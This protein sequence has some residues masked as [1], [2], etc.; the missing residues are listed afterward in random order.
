M[1]LMSWVKYLVNKTIN[2]KVNAL[3]DK[4]TIYFFIVNQCIIFLTNL[5]QKKRAEYFAKINAGR[6]ILCFAWMCYNSHTQ[7]SSALMLHLISAPDGNWHRK[8]IIIGSRDTP[9]PNLCCISAS[10]LNLHKTIRRWLKTKRR[11]GFCED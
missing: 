9:R 4:I 8:I 2:E 10:P 3:V 5:L 1:A 11:R 7:K 6:M